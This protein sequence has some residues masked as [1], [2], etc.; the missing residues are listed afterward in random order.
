MPHPAF[1]RLLSS[2]IVSRHRGYTPLA[3]THRCLRC[4]EGPLLVARR[5]VATGGSGGISLSDLARAFQQMGTADPTGR[6]T[7]SHAAA[8]AT[9][10]DGRG[11]RSTSRYTSSGVA[12]SRPSAA[13]PAFV[14]ERDERVGRSRGFS[15]AAPQ[16]FPGASSSSSS[17]RMHTPAL[18]G[19]A[20]PS[21]FST[22]YAAQLR[23][24][25]EPQL[26][27]E[28]ELQIRRR[29]VGCMVQCLHEVALHRLPAAQRIRRHD[30]S[31]AMLSPQAAAEVLRDHD[32]LLAVLRMMTIVDVYAMEPELKEWERLTA[33]FIDTTQQ[34]VVAAGGEEPFASR[35]AEGL[36][37]WL[38]RE[39]SRLD[40]AT[41]VQ[42]LHLLAQQDLAW[43]EAV[44]DT[45]VDT[46]SVHL[47]AA[48]RQPVS[49]AAQQGVCA[50]PIDQLTL[51]LDTVVR[52]QMQL[53][54]VAHRHLV[55]PS[56]A[57]DRK[58]DAAA[59][60][61]AMVEGSGHPVANAAFF[62]V[63]AEA[64]TRELRATTPADACATSPS[65]LQ[66]SS[67]AT[68]LFLT[69]ALRKLHWWSDGLMA[70][71]TQPL[72]RYLQLYPESFTGVVLLVGR[73]ENSTGD[74]A[75][76][77]V[78]QDGLLTRLRR[79]GGQDGV[80]TAVAA[81]GGGPHTQES[82]RGD[83]DADGA[84][85]YEEEEEGDVRISAGHAGS[86]P[87]SLRAAAS[88]SL[89]DLHAFPTFLESLTRLYLRTL[90][91]LSPT[92]LLDVPATGDRRDAAPTPAAVVLRAQMRELFALLQDDLQRSINSLDA[93]AATVQPPLLARVLRELLTTSDALHAEDG[94]DS[95]TH[96]APSPLMVEVAY[97][98]TLQVSAMRPPPLPP[99]DGRASRSAADVAT[100]HRIAAATRWRRAVRI[101]H[102]LLH[103]GLL[104]CTRNNMTSGVAAVEN[105]R[106]GTQPGRFYMP[107]DVV[108]LAPRVQAAVQAAK[109]RLQATRQAALQR[110]Q[111][112]EED[113]EWRDTQQQQQ[114]RHRSTS[115]PRF[116]SEAMRGANAGQRN[117]HAGRPHQH[118]A[119][120]A[121]ALRKPVRSTDVFAK[122]S[123][124]ISRLL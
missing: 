20:T 92:S 31:G 96:P 36:L 85:E 17:S 27:A 60:R 63:V 8:N 54:Q 97:V 109:T 67:R 5:S 103:A 79:R 90:H 111:D 83:G 12:P 101:H 33:A 99:R 59:E 94:N 19:S 95:S 4:V 49:S 24:F 3:G 58:E 52:F 122:Y 98:W 118:R 106:G 91:T 107:E 2:A 30:D 70:A 32:L 77:Y 102:L 104:R 28:L 11:A 6:S 53:T 47:A 66:L 16:K 119:A 15:N 55:L 18:A 123:M 75:L 78:L 71:L 124:A 86:A 64:L 110:L 46:V 82:H 61:R 89:I 113:N 48:A 88:L 34:N 93:I 21:A 62:H 116:A 108:G 112:T 56:A 45:L 76:L 87:S 40:A 50:L 41:S 39:V 38:S 65:S 22:T 80:A 105:G 115:A 29:D 121:A 43:S 57:A 25:D 7:T 44:L 114:Q 120:A 37:W 84:E 81:S 10:K 23:L 13:G 9:P 69:R 100:F 26:C 35:L 73:P 68:V 51:V 1:P 117:P 42:V 72:T 74:A 14:D